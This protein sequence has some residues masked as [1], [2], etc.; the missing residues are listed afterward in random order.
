MP[1]LRVNLAGPLAA[2]RVVSGEELAEA[3]AAAEAEAALAKQRGAL[4][5]QREALAQARNALAHAAGCLGAL[6]DEMLQ[7]VE[8]HL[9][10]L[11]VAIAGKVLA[12]EI[13]A[14]RY[15]IEPI[16][17]EAL[18]QAPPNRQAVIHLHPADLDALRGA[19]ADDLAHLHLEADPAVGRGEC[20]VRTAEGTVASRIADGL[21]EVR[22]ALDPTEPS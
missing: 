4:D 2:V 11:A 14:E 12:Q 6:Q 20:V 22:A 3:Q 5:A 18:R 17:R 13:Q 10:D 15:T 19:E 1:P 21:D 8:T 9:V 7:D 16:V